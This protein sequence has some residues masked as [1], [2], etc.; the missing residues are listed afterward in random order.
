MTRMEAATS[1]VIDRL[2]M[3]GGSRPAAQREGTAGAK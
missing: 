3:T 1:S 2:L